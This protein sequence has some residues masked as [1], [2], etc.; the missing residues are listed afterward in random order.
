MYKIVFT[1]LIILMAPAVFAVPAIQ[2]YVNSPDAVYDNTTD[3]WVV[4]ASD[5]ELWVITSNADSKP[6]YDLTLVAAIADT[7]IPVDGALSINGNS[8]MA[9]DYSYGNPPSWLEK[10]E[11]PMPN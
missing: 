9:D 3:T 1:F 5:F 11:Y 7:D 6:I 10:P 8:V 2:L 4:N